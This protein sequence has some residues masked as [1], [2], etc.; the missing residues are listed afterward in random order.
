MPKCTIYS[1]SRSFTSP[2][3]TK[4]LNSQHLLNLYQLLRLSLH[5]R[6]LSCCKTLRRRHDRVWLSKGRQQQLSDRNRP[7]RTEQ[8]L[9]STA[10]ASIEWEKVG[11]IVN[12]RNHRQKSISS[13]VVYAHG[14]RLSVCE[15]KR[16]VKILRRS[17]FM[18]STEIRKSLLK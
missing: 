8:R 15:T 12:P 1:T 7:L 3:L 11:E 6:V 16:E 2:V 10:I 13:K 17:I 4:L 14:K 18:F 5:L 9:T